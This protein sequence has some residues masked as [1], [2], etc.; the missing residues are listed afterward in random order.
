M[1]NKNHVIYSKTDDKQINLEFNV[2]NVPSATQ[3][4]ACKP[5]NR[6]GIYK[7]SI[8]KLPLIRTA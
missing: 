4:F 5:Y 3:Q 1:H 7:I 8:C 6:K 2:V